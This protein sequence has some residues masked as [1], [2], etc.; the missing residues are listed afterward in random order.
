VTLS[1][2]L[3]ISASP[4]KK[5]VIPMAGRGIR[6]FSATKVVPKVLLP[7]GRKPLI[8][9]AVEEAVASGAECVILVTNPRDSLIRKY[10][11]P[12]SELERLLSESGRQEDAALLRRIC[13][14]ISIVIVQQDFPRGLADS[15][16]C[17]QPMVKDEPFGVILP[18]ALMIGDRPCIGQLIESYGRYHGTVIATRL[19]QPHETE[20]YG[21][22]VVDQ[23]AYTAD[24]RV[25][26]VRSMVE[27][28]KPEVA[29]SL[30]GVFGRYV[31]EPGVFE[32]IDAILPDASGELQLTDA[33]NF[34]CA[35]HGTY[36]HLF[37]GKHFDTGEWLGHAQASIECMLADPELGPA[38]SKYLDSSFKRQ[39]E[40]I[41]IGR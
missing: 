27:K 11:E 9:Y 19:L 28:P 29:P 1:T 40:E 21:I 41:S 33:L 38:F 12:D 15:I 13:T 30:Y 14:M 39:M 10:F 5:V 25:L 18:D 16:R 2:T 32:A 35:E 22:L 26:R 8:L 36:G 37:E 6:L 20:R 17:A 3:P 7:I 4:V 24:D 31:L 23:D 34:N